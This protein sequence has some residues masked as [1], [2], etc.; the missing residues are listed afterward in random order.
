MRNSYP[1]SLEL[2]EIGLIIEILLLIS[3]N[4]V[5]KRARN[6]SASLWPIVRLLSIANRLIVRLTIW[7]TLKDKHKIEN[8]MTDNSINF[9]DFPITDD[10]SI[11][12][13]LLKAA[14]LVYGVVFCNV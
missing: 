14:D 12:I 10:S 13:I 1:G 5:I 4:G 3:W 2:E 8:P 6:L 7:L 9:L 11:P